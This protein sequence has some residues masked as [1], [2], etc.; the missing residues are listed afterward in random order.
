MNDLYCSEV[1][2]EVRV[3]IGDAK[4]LMIHSTAA[5]GTRP[6]LFLQPHSFNSAEIM[7]TGAAASY[8]EIYR[9][10][11]YSSATTASSQLC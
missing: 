8:Y 9:G 6:T 1:K 2:D 11:R 4:P 10:S 7:A 5:F 3:Q